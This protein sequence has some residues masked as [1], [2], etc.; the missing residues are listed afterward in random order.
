[1][2]DDV[3]SDTEPTGE[4]LRMIRHPL[5]LSRTA[6]RILPKQSISRLCVLGGPDELA[7]LCHNTKNVPRQCLPW[8]QDDVG[9]DTEPTGELLRMIRHLLRLSLAAVQ[10]R[11]YRL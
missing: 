6:V 7:K 9:S 4:L 11:T 2:Q 5:R 3:G 10:Q 8:V 1:M